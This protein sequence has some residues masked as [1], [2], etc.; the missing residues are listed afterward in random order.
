MRENSRGIALLTVLVIL[1]VFAIFAAA[2]VQQI[3]I[4][5]TTA[6][7]FTNRQTVGD[8]AAGGAALMGQEFDVQVNGPDGIP[9]TGDEVRPYLSFLDPWSTGA[10]G[11]ISTNEPLSNYDLRQ[12]VFDNRRIYSDLFNTPQDYLFPLHN[13]GTWEIRHSNGFLDQEFYLSR[14]G[15]DEDP[16]GDISADG[17]P[18]IAGIDDNQDGVIDNAELSP[19]DDDEDGLTEEDRVDFRND[20]LP[21]DSVGDLRLEV[22]SMGW[23]QD[24]DWTGI[25]PSTARLN[26]NIAGNQNGPEE[27]HIYSQGIH[28][29]ELDLETFLVCLVGGERGLQIAHGFGAGAFPGIIRYRQGADQ[30]PGTLAADDNGNAGGFD[31]RFNNIDDDLDGL[32]DEADEM[33]AGTADPLDTAN[34]PSDLLDNRANRAA[35]LTNGQDDGGIPDVIDDAFEIDASGTP[36]DPGVDD[37][38]ESRP[39]NPFRD[40]QSGRDTPFI[41]REELARFL[42][43]ANGSP[44]RLDGP[45]DLPANERP[46]VFEILDRYITVRS[47]APRQRRDFEN[48]PDELGNRRKYNPNLLIAQVPVGTQ[49]RPTVNDFLALAA[50]DN[51]GDWGTDTLDGNTVRSDDLNRNGLPDGDWDGAGESDQT[52]NK[53]DDRDGFPDDS[54]DHNGDGAPTYD[55]EPRINE[56]RQTWGR[57]TQADRQ[58]LLSPPSAGEVDPS[59]PEE[60]LIRLNRA[61]NER[62]RA[63][64]TDTTESSVGDWVFGDQIDNNGNAT[65][66]MSDGI[67]NDFD[68]LTDETRHEDF[69]RL[70]SE[71]SGI[72]PKDAWDAAADEGVDEIDE[73]YIASWDDDQDK[74]PVRKTTD[75]IRPPLEVEVAGAKLGPGLRMDEDP[76]EA[77]LLANLVDSLDYSV[78]DDQPDGISTVRIPSGSSTQSVTTTVAY[79]NEA[80]RITE[81][82]ARPLM[83]LQPERYFG[84]THG[85]WTLAEDGT[86]YTIDTAA[87]SGDVWVFPSIPKGEYYVIAYSRSTGNW[88]LGSLP[89][90]ANNTYPLIAINPA[91][92]SQADRFG[93]AF[94]NVFQNGKAFASVE[95]VPVLEDGELV[96]QIN[97]VPGTA[98]ISFDYVELYAPDAQ[99]IELANFGERPISLANWEFRVG[100]F[101]DANN[102][103]V[104]DANEED[105][106]RVTRLKDEEDFVL[107]PGQFAVLYREDVDP[108]DIKDDGPSKIPALVPAAHEG[109]VEPLILS[110]DSVVSTTEPLNLTLN[111]HEIVFGQD[112]TKN[113]EMYAPGGVLMDSFYFNISTDFCT[114]NQRTRRQD[115]V[116]FAPQHRGDPTRSVLRI[117]RTLDTKGTAS[118]TD[119]TTTTEEMYVHGP[120]RFLA[121]DAAVTLVNTPTPTKEEIR[122]GASFKAERVVGRAS[123]GTVGNA[124]NGTDIPVH[125]WT[126]FGENLFTIPAT[127]EVTFHWPGILNHFRNPDPDLDDEER[128][129]LLYVRVGGISNRAVG[130]IDLDPTDNNNTESDD[131]R[132]STVYHG[133]LAYVIDPKFPDQ[134]KDILDLEHGSLRL[135]FGPQSSATSTQRL[136]AYIEISPGRRADPE[137]QD[138]TLIKPAGRIAGD[139]GQEWFYF[140][141][142]NLEGQSFFIDRRRILTVPGDDPQTY[143][144]QRS[145][146]F[147]E[148]PM[149]SCSPYLAGAFGR[150]L[151]KFSMGRGIFSGPTPS[152][153]R[154]LASRL[155]FHPDAEVEGLLNINCADQKVLTA[156]PFLPPESPRFSE[157]PARLRFAGLMSQ[158]IVM[159][160]SQRGFDGEIG[161]PYHDDDLDG[162][163]EPANPEAASDLSDIGG[164]PGRSDEPFRYPPFWDSPILEAEENGDRGFIDTRLGFGRFSYNDDG[165]FVDPDDPNS[166]ELIDEPDEAGAAG[167][168]DGPYRE[169]GDLAN[170]FLHPVLIQELRRINLATGGDLKPGNWRDLDPAT[171]PSIDES[172]LLIMMG[173][174]ANLSTV[175]SNEFIVTSRGRVFNVDSPRVSG[176]QPVPTPQPEQVADQRIE[177]ELR[178]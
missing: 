134:Y 100:S 10:S 90:A 54:G 9:F 89:L 128:F 129:P 55:P 52:N 22:L 76:V 162:S 32:T 177:V 114:P 49:A 124:T 74:Y 92:N 146:R 8:V 63:I 148:G 156:L 144:F 85:N 174:V 16:V 75:K 27:N 160:R 109:G 166:P 69:L 104:Q 86:H 127:G 118:K 172:D 175:Q 102:N 21:F 178:R 2:F 158:V 72:S 62:N 117:E 4:Q 37:L 113:V 50:L 77:P 43:D 29:G 121:E 33:A 23:D 132:Y 176:N 142:T 116:A 59:D 60:P 58:F 46:T 41:S 120:M 82:M 167:G 83:R 139:P 25:E 57:V 149:A 168:D 51:D 47:S 136:F 110:G 1:T 39:T 68:G 66:W 56:D 171:Q 88:N 115:E 5:L 157:I 65:R 70:L 36:D 143:V 161:F 119:D 14:L 108:D 34:P 31:P 61:P 93:K 122:A 169:V 154:Q 45:S 131:E 153:M 11:P 137:V 145:L 155:S 164:A 173:R 3:R 6:T 17:K 105:T 111:L 103:G 147:R 135:T 7:H 24:R 53:D 78:S 91:N 107:N 12:W 140:P 28:P 123:A 35:L 125:T 42:V 48:S 126:E 73:W 97:K 84:A 18:G 20:L 106:T 38:A 44:L 151:E 152:E 19:L 15:V 165:D 80:I 99:Y 87:Q 67:D 26:I 94:V 79:G 150:N 141:D 130:R 170:V 159:G 81:V 98:D 30:G 138:P 40:G 112:G 101:D 96:I 133:E 64:Y 71:N 13:G 95:K 163:P